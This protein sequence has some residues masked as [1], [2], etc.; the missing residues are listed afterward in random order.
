MIVRVRRRYFV[1]NVEQMHKKQP[2]RGLVSVELMA[3][4]LAKF[5][6]LIRE[7]QGGA[8]RGVRV[9]CLIDHTRD[10]AHTGVVSAGEG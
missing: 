2:L 5:G 10:H 1:E 4:A 3:P 7:V 9:G 6:L 8:V